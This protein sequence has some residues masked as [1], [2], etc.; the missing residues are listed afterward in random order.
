MSEAYIPVAVRR[1]V[2]DRANHCCQYCLLSEEDA[3]F[4]HETDHIISVKHRGLST[5]ENLAWSCFDCNR[6]KGTDIASL[7]YY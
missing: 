4:P 6:F 1:E 2:R 3:Y 7:D 5:L